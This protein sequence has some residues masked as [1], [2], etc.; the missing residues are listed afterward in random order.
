MDKLK[1]PD[2]Y[3]SLGLIFYNFINLF[4][5]QN[6]RQGQGRPCKLYMLYY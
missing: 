5:L 6:I 3:L 4:Y 1:V 2:L